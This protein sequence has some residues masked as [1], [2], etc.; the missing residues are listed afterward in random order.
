MRKETD[1]TQRIKNAVVSN[2]TIYNTEQGS[3]HIVDNE[4]LFSPYF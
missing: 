2:E 3:M 1:A 4:N